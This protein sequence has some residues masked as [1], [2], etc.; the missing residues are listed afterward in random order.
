MPR[1]TQPISTDALDLLKYVNVNETDADGC[2]VLHYL[3]RNLSQID[4]ARYLIQRGADATKKDKK[5]IT[6]LQKAL[7]GTF[8]IYIQAS[9]N[10]DIESES[11]AHTER[12]R[13]ELNQVLLDAEAIQKSLDSN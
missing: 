1:W 13:N 4:A 6:P 8:P 9:V 5:G 11:Y 2:T 10:V 3:V 7:E 12:A